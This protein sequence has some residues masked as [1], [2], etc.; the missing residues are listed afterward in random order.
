MMM[1]D[2]HLDYLRREHARLEAEIDLASRG[3]RPDEV[4]IAR[5]K[6][7]KLAVKDQIAAWSRDLGVSEVA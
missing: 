2:K 1:S 3:L 4:A 6:K 5:L 7:L